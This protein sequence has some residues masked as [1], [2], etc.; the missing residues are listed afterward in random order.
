MLG[1]R[2]RETEKN[3]QISGLKLLTVEQE[4]QAVVAYERVFE[5]L[6]DWEEKRLF[7]SGCL[8]EMVVMRELTVSYRERDHNIHAHE[9]Y[10]LLFAL[11]LL[12]PT[13]LWTTQGCETGP[14]VYPKTGESNF[15][16]I[17]LLSSQ[18]LRD[19]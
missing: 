14:T 18:L 10:T 15:V 7:K 2:L 8:R 19:P 5:T 11:I 17:S 3:F 4:S 12:R 9:L 16:Q 13:E 6:F 1:G